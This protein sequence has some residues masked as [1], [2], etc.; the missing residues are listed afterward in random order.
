VA[1]PLRQFNVTA[2]TAQQ[3]LPGGTLVYNGRDAADKLHDPTAILYVRSDDLSSTF[4]LKAGKPIEPLI[5]RANA[6]DCVQVTLKNRL[7]ATL[8]DLPGF[9]TLPMLIAGTPGAVDFNA[10]Q[11]APSKNVGLHTQLLEYDVAKSDGANVG[12]NPVQTAGPGGSVTYRWYAGHVRLRPD[13]TLRVAKPIEFGAV[14]LMPSDSIKQPSKG[15][16]GTLIIEPPGACPAANSSLV[17]Q[18]CGEDATSRAS[19]TINVLA[20]GSEAAHAFREFVLLFQN[21]VNLRHGSGA[22]ADPAVALTAQAEDP[23][24]SGQKAFNYR[25]EPMWKR[26]GFAPDQPLG[27]PGGTHE[28]DFSNALSNTQVGGDPL[29]PVF[30]AKVGQSAWFRVVH[31]GGVGRNNTFQIHGHGWQEEPYFNSSTRMGYNPGGMC[32]TTPCNTLSQYMSSQFGIGPTAHHNFI[33]PLAGGRFG[34][35]GDYLYRDQAS[36]DF[37]GGLWGIFRVTP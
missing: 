25:T 33:L 26:M 28:L 31:P 32:L 11:V 9:Y 10:N 24:D 7:P 1:A 20:S 6:G 2:V 34:I 35:A 29:T 8:P 17:N 13:G 19:A 12:L 14:N 36:M 27:G 16:I 23:E 4:K 30:T 15:A 21:S 22:A 37:D 5:L 18:P 3:A